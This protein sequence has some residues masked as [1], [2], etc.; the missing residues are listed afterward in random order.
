MGFKERSNDSCQGVT[1]VSFHFTANHR[2]F[3]RNQQENFGEL[4][5]TVV[6]LVGVKGRH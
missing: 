4:D 5:V 6:I 1:S 2:G 3:A